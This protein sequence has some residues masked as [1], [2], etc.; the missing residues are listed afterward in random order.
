MTADVPSHHNRGEITTGCVSIELAREADFSLGPLLVRPSLRE[1]GIQGIQERLEPR[2]MQVLVALGQRAGA[3]VSRDELTERCWDGRIVGD[4]AINRCISRLRRL[5]NQHN[6]FTI[7]AIARI[8]YRLDAAETQI[9]SPAYDMPA[10][11]PAPGK[12]R[13]RVWLIA[14]LG[15]L[16]AGF[17]VWQFWPR[18][19]QHRVA[20][21]IFSPLTQDK[22]AKL[23]G[24]TVAE[25]IIAVLNDNQLVVVAPGQDPADV[26]RADFLLDGSV[27]NGPHGLH[28]TVHLDRVSTHATLWTA[29]FDQ[30][31]SHSDNSALQI[32]V[33]ARAVDEVKAA[34]RALNAGG[35]DDT[36]LTTYLKAEEFA[37]QGGLTPTLQRRDLMR[38]IVSQAPSFALGYSALA[39]T[40]AQLLSY[41]GGGDPGVLRN[42]AEAAARHALSLDPHNGEAYIALALITPAHDYG[43]QEALYRQGLKADPDNPTLNSNLAYLMEHVGRNRDALALHRRAALLDPLSPR[44]LAGYADQLALNGN[45]TEARNQFAHAILMAPGNVNIWASRLQML[46]Q[47]ATPDEAAALMDDPQF[48]A[49]ET[50]PRSIALFRSYLAARR[51]PTPAAHAAAVDAIYSAFAAGLIRSYALD[52]MIGLGNTDEAF[53]M[54]DRLYFARDGKADN[55]PE[56][57][58]LF[59]PNAAPLR[60][61]PR[62]IA[63][64]QRLGLFAY[65][66][67]NGK[68][69]FCYSEHAAV[70]QALPRHAP[71]R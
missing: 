4:D 66:T 60:R 63:L 57:A 56:T 30:N 13:W 10:T 39:L 69:D 47:F 42:D 3:V 2:V 28:V 31:N 26:R 38:R 67:R 48:P 11:Q 9:P 59:R 36:L 23:F 18:A 21:Q 8:G 50:D 40:S 1:V 71:E 5:G 27:Q 25:Q 33:A 15:L 44:K 64:V 24:K 12:P 22:T 43:A 46:D 65:W 32:R 37:R 29:T 68:P 19:P 54:A 70:C 7:E 51:R 49:A 41:S 53:A 6:A 55:R 58:S 52:M 20:V 14:V 62:F 17:V 35:T 61:D 45:L 34:L 16:L